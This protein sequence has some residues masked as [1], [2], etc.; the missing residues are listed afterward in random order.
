MSEE[1]ITKKEFDKHLTPFIKPLVFEW[2][3]RQRELQRLIK[4][5]ELIKVLFIITI[6]TITATA[7]ASPADQFKKQFPESNRIEIVDFRLFVNS[8]KEISPQDFQTITGNTEG[9]GIKYPE[10]HADLFAKVNGNFTPTQALWSMIYCKDDTTCNKIL[11]RTDGRF[12][13]GLG[14]FYD[15]TK[16]RGLNKLR[17]KVADKAHF[18][19]Y[20]DLVID[21]FLNADEFDI[22]YTLVGKLSTN[23]YIYFSADDLVFFPAGTDL[24]RL[25]LKYKFQNVRTWVAKNRVQDNL[26]VLFF[27]DGLEIADLDHPDVLH[28]Q[29]NTEA[30]L[31]IGKVRI[32]TLHMGNDWIGM[33][34]AFHETL[35]RFTVNG[36]IVERVGDYLIVEKE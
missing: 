20:N 13:E 19:S 35:K 17:K 28:V 24:Q 6:L 26:A 7:F 29:H 23:T 11:D 3:D 14:D 16:H 8:L 21:E 33:E 15:H 30:E 36:F 10:V 25:E 31:Y 32:G 4:N 1:C 22:A 12:T 9:V 27:P 2:G 5:G 18:V 34:G